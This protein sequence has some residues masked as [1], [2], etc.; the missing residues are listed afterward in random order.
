MF[1][2]EEQTLH[3][4]MYLN[5]LSLLDGETFMRYTPSVLAASS[6]ALAC[7]TLGLEAWS[8]EMAE[9]SGYQLDDIKECL[10]ALHGAFVAAETHPQQA[11]RDKYKSSKFHSVADLSPPNIM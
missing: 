1:R 3:L 11:I 8:D 6:V 4:S 9:I 5:E 2:L 10:V 7:H